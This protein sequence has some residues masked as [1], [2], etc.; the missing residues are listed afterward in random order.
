[1]ESVGRVSVELCESCMTY[2]GAPGE[3]CR[4]CLLANELAV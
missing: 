4:A 3:L 1:M 2:A